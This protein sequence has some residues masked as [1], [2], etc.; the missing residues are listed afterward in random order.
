[1]HIIIRNKYG[2]NIFNKVYYFIKNIDILF[3]I[4]SKN[5]KQLIIPI[6]ILIW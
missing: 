6:P 4:L 1:M 3:K 5:N 2:I